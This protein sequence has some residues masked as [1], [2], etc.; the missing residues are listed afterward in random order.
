MLGERR[1]QEHPGILLT[2][3]V[4]PDVTYFSENVIETYREKKVH[5]ER[6]KVMPITHTLQTISLSN[7]MASTTKAN[8]TSHPDVVDLRFY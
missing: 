7:R 6:N 5:S 2:W 3:I 4:W 8:Q 1:F